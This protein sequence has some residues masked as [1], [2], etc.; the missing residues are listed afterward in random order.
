M[1]D[2]L[3]Y[4]MPNLTNLNNV[5]VKVPP[6][7]NNYNRVGSVPGSANPALNRPSPTNKLPPY[8]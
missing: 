7:V 6:I 3:S 8:S 4:P 2:E 1:K 5:N